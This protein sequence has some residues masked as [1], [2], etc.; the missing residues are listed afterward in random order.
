M[1]GAGFVHRSTIVPE[2]TSGELPIS[3]A[4]ASADFRIGRRY[5]P[6]VEHRWIYRFCSCTGRG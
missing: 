3:S 1:E 6:Y 4:S 5:V 2:I